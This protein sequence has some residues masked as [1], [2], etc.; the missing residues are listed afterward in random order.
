MVYRQ[1]SSDIKECALQ[2]WERGWDKEDI[3]NA[4]GISSRSLFRW[5]SL[6]IEL[7]SVTKPPSPLRGRR[8]ILIQQVLTAVKE[9][10]QSDSDTYL[11]ELIWWLA[12][13]HDVAI[14]K[15]ALQR[16]IS[17]AGLSRKLLHKLAKERDEVLR[18]EFRRDI[19]DYSGGTAEEFVCLDE[20]SK[21][22]HDTERHYGMAPIGERAPLIANFVRGERYS[23]VAA[24]T[25]N[26]G[27]IATQVVVGSLNTADFYDFVQERVVSNIHILC[28]LCSIDLFSTLS[29]HK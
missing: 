12:I 4:L 8:R 14:S 28:A 15:S 1:I 5:K 17:D 6:F 16:N 9:I 29:F 27:Y 10:Y 20:V 23:L 19:K 24:I 13:H 7:G 11:D 18:A 2:L 3:C 21:N 22:D 25:A 26:D